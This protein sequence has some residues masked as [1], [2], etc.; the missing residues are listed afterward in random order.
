MKVADALAFA[1]SASLQLPIPPQASPQPE[2]PQAV[3]G[4]AVSM[5]W[6]PLSKFAL[7][8]EPQSIP[9]GELVT[10]PLGPP[11]TETERL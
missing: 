10:L 8:V 11:I 6:V 1:L 5:T 3:A 4:V 9:P 2:R 7:Q